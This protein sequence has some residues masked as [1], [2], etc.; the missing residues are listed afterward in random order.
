MPVSLITVFAILGIIPASGLAVDIVNRLTMRFLPPRP[1]PKLDFSKGIPAEYPTLVVIPTLLTNAAA[2]EECVEH[3]Q[4]HY[5][6]NS[7]GPLQFAL[8]TD[9]IDAPQEHMPNDEA[10]LEAAVNGVNRLNHRYGPGPDGRVRFLIFHR[11]RL[12]NAREGVWMGWERKRGKL[13]EL[14][15]LLRGDTHTTFMTDLTPI[16]PLL[17]SVRYVITLDSDTQLGRGTAYRL[18]GSLA[19]PLNRAFFSGELGPRRWKGTALFNRA[20]RPRSLRAARE[21]FSSRFTPVRREL[22]PTRLRSP[23]C[24][25][26]FLAKARSWE[27]VFMTSMPLPRRWD[28]R[29]PDNSMLSHDLFEGAYARAALATDIEFFEEFPSHY[30]VAVARTHRWIRGDW[31]LL[32]WIFKRQALSLISRWKMLDNLRR[33][34]SPIASLATL[35]AAWSIHESA[36]GVWSVWILVFFGFAPLMAIVGSLLPRRVAGK[37]AN[38]LAFYWRRYPSGLRPIYSR[39]AFSRPPCLGRRGRDSPHHVP[40]LHQPPPLARVDKRRSSQSVGSVWAGRLLSA[41]GRRSLDRFNSRRCCR[42]IGTTAT[43]SMVSHFRMDFFSVGR[44]RRQSRCERSRRT[45]ASRR[46][47]GVSP[48]SRPPE[49]AIF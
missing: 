42:F 18:V 35:L 33:S 2:I 30:A 20:S 40:T 8:L 5:L 31:Q 45:H 15:R 32:P 1:M 48:A 37:I 38:R 7:E 26:I 25:R 19:H 34:L 10:L 16:T 39:T 13:E 49:L 47:A 9:W 36:S 41:H 14:N 17:K 11:R 28:A 27:K 12:W 29:V 24:I 22:I 44:S 21:R 43:A 46:G 4:V 6:A 3:L 23:M